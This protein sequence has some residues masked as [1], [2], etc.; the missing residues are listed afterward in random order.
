LENCRVAHVGGYGLWLSAG[1]K[2][3]RVAHCEFCDLGA[4]GVRVGET[5]RQRTKSKDA[6]VTGAATPDLTPDGTGSRDT[7]HNLVDN[8]FI[9]L[10]GRIFTGAVGVFI[11]HSAYN[12]VTH[13]EICDLFYTGVSVGWVWG[14]G[15]S[16]AHHN[17]ICDNHIH[18]LGWG[19]M[20][21]MGGVYTLGPSPGTLVAHNLVHHVHAYSYGGWGLYTDEGSSE[22]VLENNVVYDTK[23]G[24]F[25][26]HYG[27][28]N[29]VRN[30]IFAFSR[31]G[32]IQ[33]SREDVKCSFAL[34]RNIVYCDADRMLVGPWRNGDY[35]VDENVYWTTSSAVPLWDNRDFDEW[36][37]TSGQDQHS[38]LADPKFVDAPN[39][40]FRLRPDSPALKLGLQPIS[41]EGIGL[42]GDQA[43]QDAPKKVVRGEFILPPTAGPM[44]SSLEEDFEGTPVGQR[45][46]GAS[47]QGE[48]GQSGIRVSDETAAAGKQSLKFTD[49]A[50]LDAVYQPHL[51]YLLNCRK[52]VY[53]GVF[54]VRLEEGAI[55]RHEW[56]DS[57]RPYHAGPAI[58]F[59]PNGDLLAGRTK[60]MIV[61]QGEWIHV[62]ITCDVGP[63]ATGAFDLAIQVPGQPVQKFAQLPCVSKDFKRLQW[64]GFM[65]NADRQAVFYLDNLKLFPEK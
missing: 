27:R 40:D 17:R 41:L 47:T 38:L 5:M 31:E 14:F 9:H 34:Q 62:E 58:Q 59:Q 60:L 22:I 16:A 7:G 37:A 39:R 29:V 52:G 33:R 43:W 10:G 64:Y 15:Q 57:A 1:C 21:D 6:S 54:D 65:S 23:T 36:R 19:V 12:Q 26:Q 11:G 35:Q 53:H 8:N 63:N 44:P 2:H 51:Y 25:H 55:L 56:R 28:D 13:N 18:H 61:P 42:Y 50:G 32:Q 24:G 30:N 4:G 3:N 46:V 45:A 20:S 48:R 49:A